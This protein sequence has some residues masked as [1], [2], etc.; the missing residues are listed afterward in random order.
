MD[1]TIECLLADI[2]ALAELEGSQL[3]ERV[4]VLLKEMQSETASL[5]AELNKSKALMRIKDA[6]IRELEWQ[7]ADL[8]KPKFGANSDRNPDKGQPKMDR[9]NNGPSTP[10]GTPEDPSQNRR[11]N[12]H[13][14][15]TLPTPAAPRNRNGRG[16]REFPKHLER[17]EIYLGTPDRKC[18]CGCGGSIREYDTNETLEVI[19]A[20]YYV[21]VRQYPR[22]R[23]RVANKVVGT[24][25]I[26]RVFPQTTMSNGVLASAVNTS[27]TSCRRCVDPQLAKAEAP[28][29]APAAPTSSPRSVLVSVTSSQ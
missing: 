3:A 27:T 23:C 11:N 20:R 22:Y 2:T 13:C 25:F 18:P 7:I 10:E 8:K 28:S 19:P 29:A 24:P 4:E 15:S 9:N 6:K 16:K 12:S 26:P 14:G 5:R 17:R 1:E 21:A